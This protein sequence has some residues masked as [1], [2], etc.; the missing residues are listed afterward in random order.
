MKTKVWIFGLVC[1][2][3]ITGCP[4]FRGCSVE[5]SDQFDDPQ[6]RKAAQN[7]LEVIKKNKDTSF[8]R[9]LG[10]KNHS[11]VS[12]VRLGDSLPRLDL[13]CKELLVFD[14]TKL[15]DFK[16]MKGK[17]DFLFRVLEDSEGTVR[18]RS[19]V[20]IRRLGE[21]ETT[22]KPGHWRPMQ[23][24]A[25]Y[26][27]ARIDSTLESL[28]KESRE[29]A[30]VIESPALSRVFIGFQAQ[31]IQYLTPVR[32]SNNLD[33]SCIHWPENGMLPTQQVFTRLSGCYSSAVDSLCGK[34]RKP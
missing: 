11:D 19:F 31:G 16:L 5:R 12:G 13:E 8:V 6:P 30:V 32:L 25:S 24:G 27:H 1:G 9:F 26:Y 21:S 34:Y 23:A 15:R 28:P 18:S 3:F 2:A 7:F 29:N 33:T 17:R 20:T 4:Q 14:T 10:L 22:G